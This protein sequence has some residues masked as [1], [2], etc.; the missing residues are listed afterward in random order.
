MKIRSPFKFSSKTYYSHELKFL[1][2]KGG[3]L[4]LFSGPQSLPLPGPSGPPP[5]A[6]SVTS[7]SCEFL[8]ESH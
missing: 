2:Q 1:D 4:P 8:K 5:E 7:F 6:A 3:D